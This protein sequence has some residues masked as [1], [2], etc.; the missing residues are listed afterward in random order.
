MIKKKIHILYT[1]RDGAW[2][3]G[4]QFLKALKKEMKR[5]GQ[6]TDNPPEAQYFLFNSFPFHELH[7]IHQLYKLKKQGKILIH[8]VDGPISQYRGK[9]LIIDKLIYRINDLFADATVFQSKWSRE[10]NYI[11]G[12]RQKKYEMII[13]NAPDNSIFSPS[14]KSKIIGEKIKIIATSW[15]KNV[16]KGFDVYGYL[17]NHLDYSRFEMTFVGN[18]PISFKHIRHILPQDSRKLSI[19]L[20]EHDIFI[21]ASQKDPCSNSLIEALAC[22]LP[23]VALN[24]G[25]HSELVGGGGVLFNGTHD[26][27]EAINCVVE[28]YKTYRDSIVTYRIDEIAQ[29]YID[30]IM[31]V[32]SSPRCSHMALRVYILLVYV[33]GWDFFSRIFSFIKKMFVQYGT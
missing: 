5:R 13:T 27:I 26:I 6:Y 7:R 31:S 10:Q 14:D 8:R 1:E 9:D 4:N 20:R 24:D 19:L 30:F 12:M 22:G 2:G 21:T 15:S 25:G 3:G 11:L 16:R 23:I 29:K 18:S 33:Y 32:G 17:D 28:N